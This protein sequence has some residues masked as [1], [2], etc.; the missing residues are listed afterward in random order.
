M[1][2]GPN[3]QDIE[4]FACEYKLGFIP[5][6]NSRY[7]YIYKPF[8][9]YAGQRFQ[10]AYSASLLIHNQPITAESGCQAVGI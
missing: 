7:I 8:N 6:A 3:D 10:D 4:S 5:G 9:R 1:E 2:E